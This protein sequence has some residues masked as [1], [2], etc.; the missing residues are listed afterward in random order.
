MKILCDRAA[1]LE[2]VSVVS[3]VVPSKTTKPILQN[4]LLRADSDGISLFATDLEMC[5]TELY[6][7]CSFRVTQAPC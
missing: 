5:R 7:R 4:V 6:S 3:S 2:A 1:L